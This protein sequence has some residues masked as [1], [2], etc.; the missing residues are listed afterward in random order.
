[1]ATVG[2]K[3]L[4]VKH[5]SVRSLQGQPKTVT[6]WRHRPARAHEYPGSLVGLPSTFLIWYLSWSSSLKTTNR[7]IM[8]V[9]ANVK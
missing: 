6:I 2:V 5:V 9:T 3:G 7:C 8:K 1:M 4:R